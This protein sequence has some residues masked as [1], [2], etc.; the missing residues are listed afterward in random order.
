MSFQEPRSLS[1]TDRI[2]VAIGVALCLSCACAARS[3]PRFG[4][5]PPLASPDSWREVQDLPL[6]SE[7]VVDLRSGHRHQGRLRAAD[8][9]AITVVADDA[10]AE[11]IA[12]SE[13]RALYMRERR[14]SK[15]KGVLIGAAVGAAAG[16]ALGAG[17]SPQ[18]DV[19]R[20]VTMPILGAAG[21]A[22]GAITGYVIS[23]SRSRQV[24]VYE[25]P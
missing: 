13:V 22:V 19:A 15:A 4:F 12:R 14:R 23:T 5:V 6:N 25:A 10:P 20:R 21:A 16:M 24:L 1:R 11:T 17:A 9:A 7:V 18:I 3:G 8:S 2:A